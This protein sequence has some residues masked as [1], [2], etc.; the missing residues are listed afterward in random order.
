MQRTL[1]KKQKTH[2]HHPTH[3]K[4]IAAAS[5]PANEVMLTLHRHWIKRQNVYQDI[6]L[7][8]YEHLTQ[9]C[10]GQLKRNYTRKPRVV[11]A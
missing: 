9:S 4:L 7:E 8:L 1:G 3:Y 11:S 6:M 10:S 5:L 2:P